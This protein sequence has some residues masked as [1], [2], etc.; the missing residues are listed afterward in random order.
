MTALTEKHRPKRIRDFA[1]LKRAKAIM[2]KLV[3][4]PYPSAW[5]FTGDSGTGK[6]TLALAF[7]DELGAQVI[8]V[9]AAECTVDKVRWIRDCTASMPMFGSWYVV[10]ID[11]SDRMTP[12]AQLAFLS[13]L[14]ATGF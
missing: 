4:S 9:P 12:A 5:L 13:L 1:G 6:T 8:H 14:D 3:S 7:A 10:L 2:T 11:E